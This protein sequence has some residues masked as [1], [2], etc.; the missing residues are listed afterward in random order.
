MTKQDEFINNIVA[1]D[2][3]TLREAGIKIMKLDICDKDYAGKLMIILES[4]WRRG[5]EREKEIRKFI[6]EAVMELTKASEI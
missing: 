5:A 2:T 6:N 4:V 3:D 1:K